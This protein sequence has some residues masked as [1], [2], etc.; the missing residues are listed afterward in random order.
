VLVVH[1]KLPHGMSGVARGSVH[2]TGVAAS[3]AP[4]SFEAL[5]GDV[6]DDVDDE[7]QAAANSSNDLPS[8]WPVCICGER[9]HTTCQTRFWRKTGFERGG[10]NR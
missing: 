2:V 3:G 10:V 8:Q 1:D 7:L 5:D 9:E 6:D 4:P